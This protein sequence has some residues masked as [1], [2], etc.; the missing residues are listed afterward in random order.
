MIAAII[1]AGGASSRLGKAKLLLPLDHY[2][3]I[4]HVAQS[5]IDAGLDQI[6]LVT[7]AF[8]DI[9][10]SVKDLPIKVIHNS[11]WKLGQSTSLIAGLSALSDEIETVIFILGDQPFITPD[12]IKA[13][14]HT[15]H[16]NCASIIVPCHNNKRGNPVLFDLQRWRKDLLSLEG[17]RGARTLIEKNPEHISFYSIDD[18]LIFMD[19]DTL[20]DYQK[21]VEQWKFKN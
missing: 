5:A 7:G 8:P 16:N 11:N 20:S 10:N 21:I 6:I 15:Y 4:R 19:I 13:L 17:D 12:L 2:P 9:K 14:I 1:L 18:P 3:I